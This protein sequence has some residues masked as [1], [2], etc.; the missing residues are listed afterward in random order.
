M[1][2]SNSENDQKLFKSNRHHRSTTPIMKTVEDM[3]A[4]ADKLAST[5]RVWTGAQQPEQKRA[6]ATAEATGE[7]PAAK[8]S[9]GMDYA[10]TMEDILARADVC[11]RGSR[12][13]QPPAQRKG[14]G[15]QSEIDKAAD[16][17]ANRAGDERKATSSV[18]SDGRE[19]PRRPKRPKTRHMQEKAE[20]SIQDRL[21]AVVAN[22]RPALSDDSDSDLDEDDLRVVRAMLYQ[23]VPDNTAKAELSAWKSWSE[24]CERLGRTKWRG[25]R[26]GQKEHLKLGRI[27][28]DI[29]EHML[30]RRKS[31]PAAKPESAYKV[32]LSV[33]RLM[34]REGED[35]PNVTV[36]RGVIKGLV[37]DYIKRHGFRTLVPKRAAAFS[38][39][40]ARK[41]RS[42]PLGTVIGSWT[43]RARSLATSSWRCMN[44]TLFNTGMRS[45]EVCTPSKKEGLTGKMLTRASLVFSIAGETTADPSR[46]QLQAMT[47]TDGVFINVRPSK[48]DSDGSFWCDKP[49]WLPFRKYQEA[50]ACMD[51]VRMELEHPCRGIKRLQVALFAN[52]DASPFTKYQ[53]DAA[54]TSALT[55]IGLGSKRESYTWHSYRVTLACLLDAA[56]C[57]PE[58][59]KKMVRWISDESLRTYI[60]PNNTFITFWLDK[61][62][63]EKVYTNQA[64]DLPHVEEQRF[65]A[66]AKWVQDMGVIA[67]YDPGHLDIVDAEQPGGEEF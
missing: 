35:V 11:A 52:D 60:R 42:L 67:E 13:W 47:A 25:R 37:V 12:I 56:K 43:L 58:M 14:G 59:I 1:A 41:L 66:M 39:E 5:N 38:V 45:D 27:V 55:C 64:R 49:I 53:I 33:K 21:L 3:L 10:V 24:A 36:V 2:R 15:P 40:Q 17:Q 8:A 29:Y 6:D 62:V 20:G 31:D 51:F 26:T 18:P 48:T 63:D 4:Q 7:A 57:P 16:R 9:S 19:Q 28:L 46:Q 65:Q 50:N 22:H 34:R 32:Y 23:G 44:S 54:L 61:I 30:P